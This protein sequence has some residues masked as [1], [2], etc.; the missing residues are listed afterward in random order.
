[1]GDLEKI[2]ERKK[3][4]QYIIGNAR[5]LIIAFILFTVIVVM[6]TD[7]RLVTI[8]SITDLG[9]EFFLLLFSSYGMYICCAD[10]GIKRGYV[11]DIYKKA[12]DQFNDLKLKIEESYLP[13]MNDFC[14]HYIDEELKKTRMQFLSLACIPYSLKILQT[15][16]MAH[17]LKMLNL[18]QL[19]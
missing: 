10:G 6:T 3:L 14:K 18:L 9:L 7:I 1:M 5:T 8:S 11:T 17:I 15:L 16:V 2:P 19:S 12:V 4:S 13:R